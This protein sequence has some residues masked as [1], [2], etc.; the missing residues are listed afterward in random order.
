MGDTVLDKQHPVCCPRESLVVR[1]HDEGD[2][3]LQIH[4]AHEI[5]H[6]LTGAAVE[7]AGRFI[8]EHDAWVVRERADDSARAADRR[9]SYRAIYEFGY[10]SRRAP[11]I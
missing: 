1:N 2:A 4:L 7:V 9:S 10:S 11:A 3:A 8:R 6:F 5:K